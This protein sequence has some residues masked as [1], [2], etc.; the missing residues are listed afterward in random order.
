MH[1]VCFTDLQSQGQ[2]RLVNW[3]H[4]WGGRVE[5]LYDE[6]NRY[7]GTV[8]DDYWNTT[9]AEVLCRELGY[10]LGGEDSSSL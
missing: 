4:P 8:C 5:I 10:S 9:D 7:W 2:V 3:D 1:F 6:I